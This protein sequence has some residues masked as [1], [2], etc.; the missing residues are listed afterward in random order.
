MEKCSQI[1]DGGS[2][3]L[4]NETSNLSSDWPRNCNSFDMQPVGNYGD[5]CL[6]LSHGGSKTMVV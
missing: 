4:T 2:Q 1:S 6:I 3:N 5:P